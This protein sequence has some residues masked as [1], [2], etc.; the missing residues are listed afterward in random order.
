MMIVKTGFITNDKLLISKLLH[1]SQLAS[2]LVGEVN[3]QGLDLAYQ[4]AHE[5][6]ILGHTCNYILPYR[7][8][9]LESSSVGWQELNEIN[10]LTSK[11]WLGWAVIVGQH[12]R[13]PKDIG[14]SGPVFWPSKILLLQSTH[15]FF[16][17]AII[18]QKILAIEVGR[19]S[20]DP[21][22]FYLFAIATR[23]PYIYIP[24]LQKWQHIVP[25]SLEKFQSSICT[26]CVLYLVTWLLFRQIL[27]TMF[28]FI[29]W[30]FTATLIQ[31]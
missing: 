29:N 4:P 11:I 21:G 23:Y 26:P 18:N 16:E 3:T 24:D 10:I 5:P 8:F 7:R 19:F 27:G 28:I 15:C 22:R 25:V 6:W 12:T 1:L 20:I 17:Y 14:Q 2:C 31:C 13:L 9:P 30:H